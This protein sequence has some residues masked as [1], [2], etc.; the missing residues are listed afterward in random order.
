MDNATRIPETLLDAV[1]YFANPDNAL[2]FMV[3]MRWPKGVTCPYCSGD[4]TSFLSSRRI[5][6]C[7]AKECRKQFSA[8]VGTIFEDSPI[9]LEKWLPCVWLIVNAKNGISSYEVG[10]A[11]GVTQKST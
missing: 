7:M 3:E 8:K 9:S 4:R 11:L 6:K 5:W 10:R 1:T 2:V